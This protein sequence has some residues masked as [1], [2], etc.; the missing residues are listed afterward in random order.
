[1]LLMAIALTGATLWAEPVHIGAGDRIPENPRSDYSR[2]VNWRPAEGEVVHL[3][4]PRMSWPYWP[5]W[6]HDWTDA[7]HTFQFQISANADCSDPIVDV[8][9]EINFYNTIPALTGARQWYWRVGYDVGATNEQWSPIRTFT[10]AGDA[11]TWDRAALANPPLAGMGHPRVLFNQESLPRVRELAQTNPESAAALAYLRKQ[12]DTILEKPWWDD[13][14]AA[15]TTRVPEQEFHAIAGDLATV[16]FV[17]RMTGDAKYAGVKERA[18]TWASYPPGGRASPEILGGDGSED[19]TQGNEFL[20]L[21]FD[22]LYNDLDEPQRQTMITS[23]EW[24]IDHVMN[25]HVWRTTRIPWRL[26]ASERTSPPYL[27][28]STGL[29]GCVSSHSYEATMDT[30]VCGLVLYEHSAIGREWYNVAVNYLIGITCGF[31]FDEAW[32]EGPGYGSSK[33]KWLTNASLYFDTALPEAGL[34]RNPFYSRI[35][36]WFSRVIPVGMPHNAWGN[37]A[38][39]TKAGHTACFRKLAYLTGNGRFLCNWREY[40]NET[41]AE[42][43]AW[44]EYV[45]PAHYAKP[46]PIPEPENVGLFPVA[47]WGMAATGPPNLADTFRQGLGLVFQC[48]PRGGYSHSFN[49]DVSFQLHAYG[50]MLNHGGGSSG[51]RDAYAYHSMSHNTIL[52][53]G[54]GQAQPDTDQGQR[55][56]AYGRIAG[57]AR[58]GNHVYFA[59]DATQCYPREPGDYSRWSLKLG[60]V[61]EERALP[62]LEHF[63]RHILF[64]KDKYFVIYDD[65]ACDQPAVYTWLYHILPDTPLSFD[66]ESFVVDYNAGEVKVRLQQIAHP[67]E[68]QLDDRKGMDAFINPAT[69]EDYRATRRG[70]ILCGHNLWVSNATPAKEWNF[71]TV[72]YPL[73]PGSSVF[74]SIERLDDHTVRVDEDVISFNPKTAASRDAT[75]IVDVE[76]MRPSR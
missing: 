75:F 63:V 32:N 68:L 70:D 57:F 45:L 62:Y 76:A 67:K 16:C 11:V 52:I 73:N 27:V 36:E 71:L 15:D 54:L 43:R 66:A 26:K 14:P 41:P 51:N 46:D 8:S 30:A 18:V 60:K 55:Y 3:N 58:G 48:R 34:G 29:S 44:T 65:L 2:F 59:G 64:V 40:G 4:P 10:I 25:R 37:Q 6:P 23:L 22:W 42:F 17:W 24:R 9:T 72:I 38:N 33:C 56:P 61:Y 5:G 21:L 39:V 28:K 47:G 19:A 35:G 1:M 49:S 74:P 31:G 53:D 20:A 69:G 13:F 7:R 12:A 50:Q